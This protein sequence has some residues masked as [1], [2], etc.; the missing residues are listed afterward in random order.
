MF[1]RLTARPTQHEVTAP[2]GGHS[3]PYGSAAMV[4]LV[5][6]LLVRDPRRELPVVR[7]HPAKRFGA[8]QGRAVIGA[9]AR[10][11]GGRRM[12]R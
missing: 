5:G 8:R 12:L 11:D 2:K 9:I 3:P 10:G 6:F 7:S 4:R 1:L